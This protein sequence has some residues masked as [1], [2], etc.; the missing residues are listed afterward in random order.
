MALDAPG[1]PPAWGALMQRAAEL[2]DLG[3]VAALTFWDGSTHMPPRGAPAR[4]EQSATLQRLS[5]D[6]LAD[7]QVGR[8]LDE[9]EPWAESEDPE[10]DAVRAVRLMRRDFE[11]S[12][13][14][15]SELAGDIARHNALGEAAWLRA[16][17]AN[18]FAHLRDALARSVDLRRR[19]AACFEAP[20]AYDALLDDYEP[21]MTTARLRPLFAELRDALVPL[22]AEVG[23]PDQPRNGGV[24]HGDFPEPEQ[25]AALHEILGAF[26]FDR[27]GWRLDRAV[28]PFAQALSVGDV[29]ITT[30]YDSRDLAVSLYSA[31][32]EF[33]HGHYDGGVDPAL[34][35]TPLGH[36]E[37]LG[38]HE[39]QSRMW[40]N[41]VCRSRAFC[42]WVLPVLRRHLGGLDDL[43]PERMFWGVNTVQPSLIRIEADEATYNLHVILRFELELALLDGSLEVDA[44]PEAWDAKIHD[45]L[46]LT[47]PD[48]NRGVLQDIHWGTGLIGYF[49]TYALGNLVA[50]QLWERVRADI[51]DL[52]EAIAGGDFAT[53][54][55]WLGEHVHRHGR[56]YPMPDLLRRVTGDELA[57]EPFI[58]YLRGKLA[59]A[60]VLQPA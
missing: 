46:G 51:P 9:L 17:E 56:R 25:E 15:P 44:L 40:E 24:L 45:F 27:L 38:L 10:S 13:R 42:T 37:S 8:W 36:A 43:T 39:S 35:R 7:P 14:V 55:A 31:M 19:Y 54:R 3:G 29:R 60:G 59:D 2:A 16:R 50:A 21:G 33:G 20:E 18:D 34:E 11:K 52:D 5:H 6:R 1:A 4:A 28:H 49:P 30:H 53:L 26:G 58:R 32:H 41:E 57:V 47:V 23:D 12:V 22:V 48:P